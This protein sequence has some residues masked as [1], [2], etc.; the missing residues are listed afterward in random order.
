[1]IHLL[2]D[3]KYDALILDTPVLQHIVGTDD[4]CSYFLIGDS[5]DAF[6]IAL[7][8]PSDANRT[9]IMDFSTSMVRK[10]VR[11][12]VAMSRLVLGWS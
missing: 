3:G 4:H 1:M 9:M 5:F 8:F 2:H 12:A 10:Q 7:A 11:R 6:S